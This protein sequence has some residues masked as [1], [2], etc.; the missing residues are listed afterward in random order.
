[1]AWPWWPGVTGTSKDMVLGR[2]T[3]GVAHATPVTYRRVAGRASLGAIAVALMLLAAGLMASSALAATGHYSSGTL[4]SGPANDPGTFNSGGPGGVA[5]DQTS[6]DVFVSDPGHSDVNFTPLPRIERFDSTGAFQSEFPIDPTA[7][8]S[9]GTL[10]IDPA[11][12]DL[13]VSA[14]DNTTFQGAILKY[15]STGTFA[16][17]LDASTTPGTAFT[18]P[19]AVAV[20]PTNGTVYVSAQD[21]T[22]GAYVI[23]VFDNAGAY[24]STIAGASAPNGFFGGIAALAV[25][26]QSRLY[27]ADS[28]FN[29]VERYDSTGATHQATVD[30]GTRG[31]PL[32]ITTDTSNDEVYV[33][34]AGPSGNVVSWFSAGGA[35]R[36]ETF[37][38]FAINGGTGVAVNETSGT[39]YVPDNVPSAVQEF[40]TFSGPTV[41]T[42]PAASVD[43]FTETLNGTVNPE[44]SQSNYHFEWSTDYS[45]SFMG[46]DF[47][48]G[49]GSADVPVTDT[50]FGLSPNTTYHLR[51]AAYNIDGPNAGRFIYSQDRTFTTAPA[52]PLVDTTG[53]TPVTVDGATL[54]G[55]INPQ[56]SDSTVSF[57]Y[58][59]TT[60][61]GTTTTPEAIGGIGNQGDTPVTPVPITGLQPGTT[62]HYRLNADNGTG[63][64]QNGPDQTFTTAPDSAAVATSVTGVTAALSGAVNAPTVATTYVF[65][66]GLTPAYGT[67][68]EP[69]NV[70]AGTGA[71]TYTAN[72]AKLTPG[73]T[74]HVR[75]VAIDQATGAR[76]EGKDG[77]FT[78][79]P[80]P[81][82]S[83][84]AVSGVGT[85][86]ATFS[87]TYETHGLGGTYQF[88]VDSSTST[89]LG[90]TEPKAVAAAGAASDSLTGLLP[91]QT[92]TVRIAVTSSGVTT[93]G[94]TVT[95][96]TPP[97]PPVAPPAPPPAA[98]ANPYGCATPV[99]AAYNK[100][101]KPGDTITVLGSDLGVGGSVVLGS[102]TLTPTYW[103]ITGFTVTLPDDAKGTLPLTINCG[104]VSNT[105][106][107]AMY[108]APS[109]TITA[110]GKVTGHTA[111]VKVKVPGPGSISIR[112]GHV[113]TA[114][115]HA[116]KATTYSVKVTLNATAVKS[117]KR[118]K[119]LAVSL[120][121]RFT[122][123]GGTTGTK[124]VKVTFKR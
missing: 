40:A 80:A 25:D 64:V 89:Y 21:T 94:D 46:P 87:G 85:D 78:T 11:G 49:S 1:M 37:G 41:T 63:G 31:G 23:D 88:V 48:A 9:P 58:G 112:S 34:E 14:T 123:T 57:E 19:A 29:T 118:H 107:I 66:Y 15:S 92:Y 5:I 30:D 69:K 111:T 109:N 81:L 75:V 101:P 56:G 82:A 55:S 26:S 12:P 50:A 102:D 120:S 86:R 105:I 73:T 54:I 43:P 116:S 17:A 47:D 122:P 6:G 103:G 110:S 77:T 22:S 42:D 114:T 2:N 72:I 93:L 27:V 28:A 35:D 100:H 18:N 38:T 60:A 98:S 53:A 97:V 115:K 39:V 44:G 10:A 4:G 59:L 96:S 68:T 106:A 76:T 36:L 65:E 32:R 16:Y 61:Y 95:F 20:D 70:A 8:S 124:T 84:G 71:T 74:Y 51:L 62:Y 45:Y 83:T 117:L 13:Y 7:Y 52:P 119:R 108:Q 3:S 91:G 99:L 113:K 104:T 67:T 33:L 24:Q 121:V 90:H 79:N